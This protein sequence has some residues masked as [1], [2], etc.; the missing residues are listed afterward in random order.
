MVFFS[1]PARR[2]LVSQKKLQRL[3]QG[4]KPTARTLASLVGTIISMGLALGPVARMRTRSIYSVINKASFWDQKVSLSAEALN[5]TKFWSEC[6]G[7]YNGQ[8]IWPIDPS[9]KIMTYSDASNTAWGGYVV[10]IYDQVA[11]GNFSENEIGQSST[12]RELKGTLN[13]MKSYVN[14]LKGNTVKHRT[15]N[16]N[17]VRALSTGSKTDSVHAIVIDIFKL[18]I[19]NNIQLF[20]EWIPRALN[21]V[22]DWISKDIDQDDYKLHPDLF[23]TLDILWGRHTI[24]RF[25]SYRTGQV[26]RFCSH[27]PNPDT[28]A[29][30]AFS[31]AW[32]G[33]NNWLFPPPYLL[34]KVLRH[35]EFSKADGTL[36]VPHWESAPWWPLLIQQKNIFKNFIADIFTI[37]PR[38]NVFIL[39]VP[40]NTLFGS[41]IQGFNVLAL[42][43]CFCKGLQLPFHWTINSRTQSN[44]RYFP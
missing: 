20:P 10:H 36:I 2:L 38:K 34:P 39:A 9:I 44:V 11:K 35:L 19:E 6:L 41:E 37:T 8:P 30:D 16:Q 12:W 5:E 7:D 1:V 3:A 17:V 40:Q 21:Q 28:K 23:A 24:D 32:L 27:F 33:E 15:D 31:V 42:R 25:S 43:C 18:C 22:A 14:I 13:V 29:I 4:G 26:P